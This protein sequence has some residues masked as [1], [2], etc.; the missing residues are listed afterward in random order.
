MNRPRAGMQLYT[1]RNWEEPLPEIVRRVAAAG[2]DGVEFAERVTDADPESVRAALEE[3][4]TTAISAH[5]PLTRLERSFEETVDRFDTIGCRRLVVPHVAAEHFRTEARVDALVDR[6]HSLGDSLEADGFDLTYHN[7]REPLLPLLDAF[8]L[9]RLLEV[10]EL[11]A[12]VWNHVAYGLGRAFRFDDGDLRNRT[13]FGRLV[14]RSD[15]ELLDFEVDAKWVVAA[16]YSPATAFELTRNRLPIVHVAD[17]RRE[18]R[19]PPAFEAADPG[20]GMVDI[21]G[22][23]AAAASE[24]VP[25]IV[26][27]HESPSDPETALRQGVESVVT[28]VEKLSQWR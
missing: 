16:G 10:G 24:Q 5:V 26:F 2:F 4:D 23:I 21:G 15:P 27:E 20:T 17:L 28:P 18:R 8:R 22:T 25:W 11:P 14:E 12:G 19:I 1:L 9:G 7:A 13:G 6:L 3:T